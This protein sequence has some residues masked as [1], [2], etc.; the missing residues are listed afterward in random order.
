MTIT[1]ATLMKSSFRL[2][3]CT[4]RYAMRNLPGTWP[5]SF[6]CNLISCILRKNKPNF[7]EVGVMAD[8]NKNALM[9]STKDVIDYC[10][11]EYVETLGYTLDNFYVM[12]PPNHDYFKEA[13]NTGIR[14]LSVN[15][16]VSNNY[17][18]KMEGTHI[19]RTHSI[20]TSAIRDFHF[21]NVKVYMNCIDS[22]PIS[23]KRIPVKVA[24]EHIASYAM[25]E[26]VDHVTL[27]DTTNTMPWWRMY[28]L[29]DALNDIGI[30]PEKLGFQLQLSS[31]HENSFQR[32]IHNIARMLWGLHNFNIKNIDIV[33]PSTVRN[34]AGRRNEYIYQHDD[35]LTKGLT[36]NLL[37][38]YSKII[39][40]NELVEEELYECFLL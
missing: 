33:D 2:Y 40:N 24:V 14:N 15:A 18:L 11:S 21:N 4:M 37:N 22:C 28:A 5:T 23:D 35:Y 9:R 36:Y 1:P 34:T 38:E 26:G 13:Y 25:H 16:S 32:D 27:M 6:H 17:Q 19:A 10:N 3:D 12:V 8:K 30:P 20:I 7:L 31:L 29:L 39:D